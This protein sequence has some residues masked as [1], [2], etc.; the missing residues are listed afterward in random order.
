M[1]FNDK[2]RNMNWQEYNALVYKL[3]ETFGEKRYTK[4]NI[5]SGF[6]YWKN[7]KTDDL[8][9]VVGVSISTGKPVDLATEGMKRQPKAE[10]TYYISK[11]EPID[12]DSLERLKKQN[13]AESLWD[14]VLKF[15]NVGK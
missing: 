2:V 9:S 4:Q 6:K 3:S 13:G 12:Y 11:E 7:L 15:K 14:L 8:R 10:V 5:E 1:L